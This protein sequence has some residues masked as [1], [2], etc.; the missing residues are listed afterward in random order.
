MFSYELCEI[1]KKTISYR[2]PPVAAFIFHATRLFL[3][4]LKILVN[5]KFSI[6][7][8]I[9]EREPCHEMD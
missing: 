2:A 3:Y 6:I 9:I 7:S 5:Q 8:G 4:D 1:S